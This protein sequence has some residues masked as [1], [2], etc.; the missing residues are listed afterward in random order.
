MSYSIAELNTLTQQAKCHIPYV[1]EYADTS[2]SCVGETVSLTKP[3]FEGKTYNKAF[4]KKIYPNSTFSLKTENCPFL[5][6][7]KDEK[8]NRYKLH[9]FSLVVLQLNW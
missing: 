5:V 9:I 4:S 2:H 6:F 3:F 1:S 7:F 8:H